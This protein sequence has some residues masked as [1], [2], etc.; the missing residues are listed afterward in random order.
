[1]HLI[2]W[3]YVPTKDDSYFLFSEQRK[4]VVFFFFFAVF[5][6]LEKYN[7]ISKTVL[8]CHLIEVKK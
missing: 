3:L 4:F 7:Q 1:M 6:E 2:P 5:S 8:C